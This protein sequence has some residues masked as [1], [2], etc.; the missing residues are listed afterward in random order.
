MVKFEPI[1]KK[2]GDLIKSDDWN[3]IQEDLR[4]ELNEIYE[5]INEIKEYIDNMTTLKTLI[6]INSVSGIQYNLDA[7]V[8]DDRDN[9]ATS[10]LGNITKFFYLGINTFGE[11][12]KFGILDYA[13]IMYF[14]ASAKNGNKKCL[15]VTFEYTD[16]ETQTTDDL[17]IH[18][19]TKLQP[20]LQGNYIEY[21]LSPNEHVFYRYAIHNPLPEKKIR[22]I[23]F[24]DVSKEC[25]VRIGN[26][27][28]YVSKIKN[29]R[30]V[31]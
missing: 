21:L 9:Y 13:D 29:I 12:C 10:V 25:G 28:Q 30:V 19:W 22:Y 17:F 8:P 5:K 4:S 7:E 20:K 1:K 18:E 23:S 6:N 16:G 26:A 2:P 31:K 3:K 14:W 24:T 15:R 11:I 27:I